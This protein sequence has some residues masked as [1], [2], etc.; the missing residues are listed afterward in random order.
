[1]STISSHS[2]LNISET[3]RNRGFIGG[4]KGPPIGNGRLMLNRMV[5][6]P[7]TLHDPERSRSWS[8]YSYRLAQYIKSRKWLEIE[9][10][11]RKTTIH[12]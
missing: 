1:M 8:Q 3:I 11:F 2:P 5:A 9:D 7:T 10:Q 12:Q 6:W 4:S